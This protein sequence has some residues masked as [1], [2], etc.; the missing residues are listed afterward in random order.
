MLFTEFGRKSEYW[1]FSYLE[2]NFLPFPFFRKTENEK[3]SPQIKQ[4]S[5]K[6]RTD[7]NTLGYFGLLIALTALNVWYIHNSQTPLDDTKFFSNATHDDVNFSLQA[8]CSSIG[9]SSK[10]ETLCINRTSSSEGKIE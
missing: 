10:I 9:D 1:F 3:V 4:K 5:W 7:L 2:D 6:R 8:N